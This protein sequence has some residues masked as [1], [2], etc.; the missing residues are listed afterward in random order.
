MS[1]YTNNNQPESHNGNSSGHH[2]DSKSHSSP[3]DHHNNADDN[4]HNN[5][6]FINVDSTLKHSTITAL[7][8]DEERQTVTMRELLTELKTG[9]TNQNS[10]SSVFS[11]RRSDFFPLTFVQL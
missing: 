2:P 6:S 9:N 8:K 4:P 11:A 1:T 10:P 3:R 5:N 7:R